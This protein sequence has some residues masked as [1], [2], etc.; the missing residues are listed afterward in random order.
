MKTL[1]IEVDERNGIERVIVHRD[2]ARAYSM[3]AGLAALSRLLPA[4]QKLDA[5]ALAGR[6]VK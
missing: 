6:P 2:P 4:I 1:T 5:A 3:E